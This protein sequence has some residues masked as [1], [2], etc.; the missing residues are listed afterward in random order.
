[1]NKVEFEWTY[2]LENINTTKY[3]SIYRS[4]QT[5]TIDSYKD[6][7]L[8]LRTI[9]QPS[10]TNFKEDCNQQ[11]VYYAVVLESADSESVLI[12]KDFE[13]QEE[14]PLQYSSDSLYLKGTWDLKINGKIVGSNLSQEEVLRLINE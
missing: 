7:Q 8:I 2:S 13:F 9:F 14:I 4:Y 12:L 11:K 1:M 5:F 6:Q 3:I 10:F